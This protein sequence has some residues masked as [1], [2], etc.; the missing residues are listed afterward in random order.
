MVDEKSILV[1][2]FLMLMGKR[3]ASDVATIKLYYV[4]ATLVKGLMR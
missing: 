4:L 1:C 2:S 3:K